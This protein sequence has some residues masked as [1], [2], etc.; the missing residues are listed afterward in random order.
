MQVA[1]RAVLEQYT[2]TYRSAAPNAAAVR[3]RINLPDGWGE[4][5]LAAP[6][7]SLE[8]AVAQ[9]LACRD[10]ARGFA[11]EKHGTVRA[12]SC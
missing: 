6:N 5:L 8:A 9:A 2:V 10:S 7:P 3:V 4:T 12:I 1:H 11:G